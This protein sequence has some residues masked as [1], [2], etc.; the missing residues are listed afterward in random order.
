MRITNSEIAWAILSGIVTYATI[1]ALIF[2]GLN[3]D[4]W[5]I[6]SKVI[7]YIIAPMFLSLSAMVGSI[8]ILRHGFWIN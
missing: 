5:H 4:G 2:L 8:R 7:A 6:I 3:A 1:F